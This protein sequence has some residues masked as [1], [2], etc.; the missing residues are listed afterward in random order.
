V[1]KFAAQQLAVLDL[2]AYI[3]VAEQPGKRGVILDL[4]RRAT[5]ARLRTTNV[6]AQCLLIERTISLVWRHR[7]GL[8][9]N[10]REVP[11]LGDDQSAEATVAGGILAEAQTEAVSSS[12][13][14]DWKTQLEA[15]NP[16][17]ALAY[18]ELAEEVA[19]GAADQA[20]RRLAARLFALAA[21]LDS[22]RFGR[23]AALALA[24]M[25]DDP[26]LRRRLLALA[27]LVSSGVSVT[28]DF[29]PDAANA[30]L[31]EYT[32]SSAIALSEALGYYRRGQGQKA[33]ESLRRGGADSLLTKMDRLLPQGADRIRD[34]CRH[35]K[36]QARP[37][38]SD[39]HRVRML[40]LDLALLSTGDRSWSG[41]LLLTASRPLIEV[42]P[43]RLPQTF[44]VDASRPYFRNGRWVSRPE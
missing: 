36:G 20:R 12:V 27:S 26:T 13:L 30:A 15:L 42:D 24:A 34:D 43:E 33:I 2:L 40:R 37:T 10:D 29:G 44:G 14:A 25:E 7:L 38:I 16:S 23:S 11:A 17:D 31:G 6:L 1:Q 4:L 19:D 39:E 5:D 35:Y 41:D 32:M 28:G 22:A 3:T 9:T 8:E 21:T 18:F